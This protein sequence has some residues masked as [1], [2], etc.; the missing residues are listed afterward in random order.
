MLLSG[1]LRAL[2]LRKHARKEFGKREQGEHLICAGK[3]RKKRKRK[4][5]ADHPIC[6]GKRPPLHRLGLMEHWRRK[7][8]FTRVVHEKIRFCSNYSLRKLQFVFKRYLASTITHSL[9]L[10]TSRTPPPDLDQKHTKQPPYRASREHHSN[11]HQTP[12]QNCT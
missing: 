5:R 4:R 8:V 6:L 9:V 3:Q 10:T 7:C 12:V 11:T 2:V 1:R